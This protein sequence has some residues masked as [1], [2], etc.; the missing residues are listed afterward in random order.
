[1]ET[2]LWNCRPITLDDVPALLDW[3]NDQALHEMANPRPFEPYTL[4]ELMAYWR[5]KLSREHA[6]Y[7]AIE[8]EGRLVGR[9]GLK[10]TPKGGGVV[11]YSILIGERAWH[12]RGLGTAVTKRMLQEAFADPKVHVVRLYVRRDNARALRCYEKAGFRRVHAFTQNGVPMEM[13]QVERRHDAAP[14]EEKVGDV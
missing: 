12:S 1:M 2:L 6:R 5:K 3:Y 11:E 9:A 10:G 7:F 8:V 13:M 14:C 4:D